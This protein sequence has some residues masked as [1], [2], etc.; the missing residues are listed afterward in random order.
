VNDSLDRII[1][2]S[3]HSYSDFTEINEEESEIIVARNTS[4]TAIKSPDIS[5]ITP[6]K[7]SN[8]KVQTPTKEEYDVMNSTLTSPPRSPPRG[9]TNSPGSAK[10][11]YQSSVLNEY[12]S[13]NN[14]PISS[15]KSRWD[16]SDSTKEVTLN[17]LN[18]ATNNDVGDEYDD[19][20]AIQISY[21]SKGRDSVQDSYYQDTFEEED[22]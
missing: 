12:F 22:A 8:F 18:H 7:P 2:K 13:G 20:E 11:K 21:T 14:R 6:H 5:R 17:R 9:I 4:S 16:T 1:T 19:E 15:T 3:N 10:S